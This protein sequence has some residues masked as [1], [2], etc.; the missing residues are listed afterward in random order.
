MLTCSRCGFKPEPPSA[1][2]PQLLPW[3]IDVLSVI[4][5]GHT[6]PSAA[7]PCIP[8]RVAV[9]EARHQAMQDDLACLEA[10]IAQ[11]RKE[12]AFTHAE[13]ERT[14]S[15]AAPIRSIPREILLHIFSLVDVPSFHALHPRQPPCSFGHVCRF[16]RTLSRSAPSLWSRVFV[17]LGT[18]APNSCINVLEQH[19]VLSNPHPLHVKLTFWNSNE[20]PEPVLDALSGH[21]IRLQELEMYAGRSETKCF[22]DMLSKA[23]LRLLKRL[24][25]R[26]DGPFPALQAYDIVLPSA[27]RSLDMDL[28]FNA[29]KSVQ[30]Q[31]QTLTSFVGPFAGAES[32]HRFIV[33]AENLASLRISCIGDDEDSQTRTVFVHENLTHLTL[34]PSCSMSLALDNISL[35][36]LEQLILDDDNGPHSTCPAQPRQDYDTVLSRLLDRSQCNLKTFDNAAGVYLEPQTLT[37]IW[38]MSNLIS[39]YLNL[40]DQ[41]YPLLSEVST[42]LDSLTVTPSQQP[43]P[44]L[45]EL[46]IIS[47]TVDDHL[48]FTNS[49]LYDLVASRWNVTGNVSRLSKLTLENH[50]DIDE[51][52]I[53][54]ETST[55]ASFLLNLQAQGLDVVWMMGGQDVLADALEAVESYL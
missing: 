54:Y 49:K 45:R 9:L 38:R 13:I 50:I 48:V 29:F 32:F 47:S 11:K 16:W 26:T 1:I 22:F 17:F 20:N 4:R 5:S 25:V 28:A 24:R 7:I 33:A 43:L 42:L 52:R 51:P 31:W 19:L 21:S 12:I 55:F 40:D 39:L 41:E 36:R 37:S 15:L 8:A 44:S 53:T 10:L 34:G 6:P 2:D 23:D 27:L 3:N 14:K 46:R 30:G 18:G 35:P